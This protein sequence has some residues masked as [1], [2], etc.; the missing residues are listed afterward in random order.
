MPVKI[1][2]NET[3][4]NS[5]H[6]T[7][8]GEK[9]AGVDRADAAVLEILKSQD[10]EAYR[11]FRAA[12]AKAVALP[13]V[14]PG[15]LITAELIN[16]LIDRVNAV[17]GGGDSVLQLGP[18][19]TQAHTLVA[20]AGD[21]K[22]GAGLWLDGEPLLDKAG[23]LANL[24]LLDG[25]SLKTRLALVADEQQGEAAIAKLNELAKKGDVFM[26]WLSTQEQDPA[27]ANAK[28][29][30]NHAYLGVIQA[31][32]QIPSALPFLN[33][34]QTGHLPFAWGL[35]STKLRRFVLGGA[36][37]DFRLQ[38]KLNIRG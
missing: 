16:A 35:Y 6:E 28:V 10:P 13:H 25:A 21:A 33:S 1:N 30:T 3:A 8:A 27:D 36:S 38:Q 32:G 11:I 2:I 4:R 18:L 34:I 20:L 31:D 26:A 15:D 19:A 14:Q 12:A 17:E 37:E 7:I 29:G 5:L 9:I 22:T 24:A 23:A